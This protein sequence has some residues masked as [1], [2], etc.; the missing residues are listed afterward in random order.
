MQVNNNLNI[1][2]NYNNST[3]IF[4][5]PIKLESLNLNSLKEKLN[6][7]LIAHIFCDNSINDTSLEGANFGKT[8]E[9]LV[10]LLKVLDVANIKKAIGC[11]ENLANNYNQM[12]KG[13]DQ[14]LKNIIDKIIYLNVGDTIFLL[15]GW[16][17]R[18]SGHAMLYSFNRLTNGKLEFC[19]YNTG[20]GIKNHNHIIDDYKTKYNPILKFT[21]V[22]QEVFCT[23]IEE[24][25]LLK[26]LTEIKTVE[27]TKFESDVIY[28][29]I[30]KDLRKYLDNKLVN[31]DRYIR[32]QLSGT[33]VWKVLMVLLREVLPL[34][35][36][37]ICKFYIRLNA[38]TA[39][40]DKE[41]NNLNQP[42]EEGE[43]KRVI[44]KESCEIF[45]RLMSKEFNGFID[46]VDIK[47]AHTKIE[48]YLRELDKTEESLKKDRFNNRAQLNINTIASEEIREDCRS[49][50]A[51]LPTNKIVRCLAE[52]PQQPIKLNLEPFSPITLIHQLKLIVIENAPKSTQ[53]F[54]VEQLA[55]NLPINNKNFWN[56]IRQDELQLI[57][58][59]LLDFFY[60]YQT[61]VNPFKKGST[62]KEI[63]TALTLQASIHALATRVDG[64]GDILS[65][66]KIKNLLCLINDQNNEEPFFQLTDF[67]DVEQMNE[68]NKYFVNHNSKC[69]DGE[70]FTPG[71]ITCVFNNYNIKN[72]SEL[73]FYY[74]LY[75]KHENDIDIII[76]KK[77]SI[78]EHDNKLLNLINNPIKFFES[79]NCLRRASY[80]AAS[81]CSANVTDDFSRYPYEIVVC[82]CN[83]EIKLNDY[84]Y[85]YNDKKNSKIALPSSLSEATKEYI[86]SGYN[87]RNLQVDND[88]NKEIEA[89]SN[90]CKDNTP[91]NLMWRELYREA[92]ER[93]LQPLQILSFF[94]EHIDLL[95]NIDSQTIF[96]M[97][98]FKS[99]IIQTESGMES[100]IDIVKHF[101]DNPQ[102]INNL[103]NLID[104][105]LKQFC[106][107]VSFNVM[108]SSFF[109]RLMQ[110]SRKFI[111][112]N[113]KSFNSNSYFQS[114]EEKG[115]EIN[116]L[117]QRWLYSENCKLEIKDKVLL[118]LH[119]VNNYSHKKISDLTNNEKE[120]ILISWFNISFYKNISIDDFP[121]LR[122]EV[123]IFVHRLIAHL[124]KNQSRLNYDN[125]CSVILKNGCHCN[126]ELKFKSVDFPIFTYE[127]NEKKFFKID[128]LRGSLFNES[129]EIKCDNPPLTETIKIDVF[130]NKNINWLYKDYTYTA[131]SEVFG[132]IKCIL[133]NDSTCTLQCSIN[134][135]WYSYLEK[136]ELK[137]LFNRLPGY[138][139]EESLC[140]YNS[141]ELI[142][143]K[144]GNFKKSYHLDKDGV[145][146]NSKVSMQT[147]KETDNTKI[148]LCNFEAPEYII[149]EFKDGKICNLK[150]PKY[151]S[152]INEKK[153]CFFLNNKGELVWED[154]QEF[155]LCGE[156]PIKP[157][158]NL[159]NALYLVNEKRGEK[160]LLV[161]VLFIKNFKKFY[162][163]GNLNNFLDKDNKSTRKNEKRYYLEFN[164]NEGDIETNNNSGLLFLS[165]LTIHDGKYEK[166]VD[167]LRQV[168]ENSK[169]SP[170]DLEI[171]D[172]IIKYGTAINTP[173]AIGVVLQAT[174]L[175]IKHRGQNLNIF[176]LK[177]EDICDIYVKYLQLITNIPSNI[178]LKSHEELIIL[179]NIDR[180]TELLNI[181]KNIIKGHAIE[182]S[183]SPFPKNNC[184]INDYQLS[185][186]TISKF[187]IPD[188]KEEY[189][190]INFDI[191]FNITYIIDNYLRNHEK[192]FW[193]IVQK[194][195]EVS[196]IEARKIVFYLDCILYDKITCNK[197]KLF[198]FLRFLACNIANKKITGFPPLKD[199]H[200]KDNVYMVKYDLFVEIEKLINI[201][202]FEIEQQQIGQ[203]NRELYFNNDLP[204]DTLP[205][206][207]EKV[208]L[209]L[210][211]NVIF[212]HNF[213]NVIDECF[214]IDKKN[215]NE[216]KVSLH[217]SD[218]IKDFLGYEQSRYSSVIKNEIEF[219][220]NDIQLGIDQLNKVESFRLKDGIT[221]GYVEQKLLKLSEP[222]SEDIDKLRYHILHL[223]NK[224]P[225][226]EKEALRLALAI[227]GKMEKK[228]NIEDIEFCFLTGH[229]EYFKR[230]NKSLSDQE[231][232]ELFQL[233][234]KFEILSIHNEQLKRAINHISTLKEKEDELNF[235]HYI[236]E[237][238]KE[239]KKNFLYENLEHLNPPF[240]VFTR[241][242]GMIPTESQAKDIAHLLENDN[243][244]IQKIMGGGKTAIIAS[245]WSHLQVSKGKLPIIFAHYSQYSTVISNLMGVQKKCFNRDVV[246]I[247]CQREELTVAL[248]EKIKN[249]LDSVKRGGKLL[250]MI[251]ETLQIL[252]LEFKSIQLDLALNESLLQ[253]D[254]K[255][256]KHAKMML[257]HQIL[258]IFKKEGCGLG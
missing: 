123:E 114:L 12:I 120:N 181:R 146:T 82:L 100:S 6:I 200:C 239:L 219:F 35:E 171:L 102:L 224:Q 22:P 77:Y 247:H 141:E 121:T 70:I 86:S 37:K 124:E 23:G 138:L 10:E 79:I 34:K 244:V 92:T 104:L 249:T 205:I 62:V 257:L 39:F 128:F 245:L 199:I 133:H 29:G 106:S 127:L 14:Y 13:K 233:I 118:N 65:K 182:R 30:L 155:I 213:Q 4:E 112:Q 231:I 187:D 81:F 72:N 54:I 36:Y 145:F 122:K 174:I 56:A 1:Q 142:L 255:K 197:Y 99:V 207:G 71:M 20:D 243:C 162:S 230:L 206:I 168:L 119:I 33:C 84:N 154:N 217:H 253:E 131:M 172:E 192:L 209:E 167:L 53:C 140:W 115:E 190:N 201:D 156:A 5:Q 73:N 105:G 152:I 180:P 89:I 151:F 18:S 111:H 45:S 236:Q 225:V 232:Y 97:Q 235:N 16:S 204:V 59:K 163:E 80:I 55:E 183:L 103:L 135:K 68:I 252:D 241:L 246:T 74:T 19:V 15:G 58:T 69:N 173:V 215:E 3:I 116:G 8:I 109:V 107:P 50:L 169:L 46:K 189:I 2:Q 238:A 130:D 27:Q 42:T 143:T 7:N 170:L 132:E 28:K 67:K 222:I 184:R 148:S 220:E 134:G 64:T 210:E 176:K 157:L 161:P 159:K 188:Y 211:S 164:I 83:Q 66:Y 76:V 91:Q 98:F 48:N 228:N 254:Q 179:E 144:K 149:S 11:I 44:L 108:A 202:L 150:F 75:N 88:K 9:L 24:P 61:N 177:S 223:A 25:L 212:D 63:I 52:R 126:Q 139:I 47:S 49:Q 147:Y 158:N 178:K 251:P 95:D 258:S 93:S 101:I 226:D 234:G 203:E 191:L 185:K 175:L 186:S 113:I 78:N 38:L 85:D 31:R 51:M 125:V 136:N 193:Q 26:A 17:E 214:C 242:S 43:V 32:S 41:H 90:Y 208:K 60:L 57:I 229:I 21:E 153:L 40:W 240:L 218:I 110:Y 256:E 117:L 94:K 216:S 194:F 96:F 250:V 198:Q 160:K 87:R 248:L 137:K 196:S 165:Y 237:L 221:L 129:G 195:S 227:N 166:S